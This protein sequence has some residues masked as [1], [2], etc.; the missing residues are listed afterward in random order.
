MYRADGHHPRQGP[1]E[2]RHRSF[3]RAGGDHQMLDR[4]RLGDAIA[5]IDH[6]TSLAFAEIANLPDRAAGSVIGADCAKGAG[7]GASMRIG[8]AKEAQVRRS[9]PLS[10]FDGPVDLSTRFGLLVQNH[11]IGPGA[12]RGGGGGHTGRA[13]ADDNDINLRAHHQ[14]PSRLVAAGRSY[15][16]A[17]GSNRLADG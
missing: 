9:V 3:Q 4:K 5:A 17:P 14:P 1:A 6:I 12:R 2:D 7:D 8:I 11:H 16:G 15:P 10:R 13:G